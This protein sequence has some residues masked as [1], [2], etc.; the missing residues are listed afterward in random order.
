MTVGVI[1]YGHIGTKVVQLLKPFGCR[2]LVR[3]PYVP[4]LAPRTA[5]TASSRSI[6]TPC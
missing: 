5:T 1:G 3:D 2:I 6:S 4:A